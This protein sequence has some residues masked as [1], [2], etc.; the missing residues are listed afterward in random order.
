M[1]RMPKMGTTAFL[2][3]GSGGGGESLNKSCPDRDN[4][5]VMFLWPGTGEKAEVSRGQ[6]RRGASI[7]SRWSWNEG[8]GRVSVVDVW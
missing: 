7:R 6:L 4:Y 3:G 2:A 5:C 1:D 8:R